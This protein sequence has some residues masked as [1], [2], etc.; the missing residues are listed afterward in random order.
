[1]RAR[2]R[3]KE[4]ERER[5][6]TRAFVNRDDETI[7]NWKEEFIRIPERERER[8]RELACSLFF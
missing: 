4:R 3:I 7:Q 8:E 2:E 5:N 6:A 1:M